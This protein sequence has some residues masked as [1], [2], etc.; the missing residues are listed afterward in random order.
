M[1]LP[2]YPFDNSVPAGPNN[3]SADQPDMLSNNQS[4]LLI[5]KADH[6]GYNVNS[7]GYHPQVRMP[8]YTTYS[9]PIGAALPPVILGFG[10]L[11]CNAGVDLIGGANTALFYTPD[12]TG[13]A[14]QLT[15]TDLTNYLLFGTLTQ[16]YNSVGNTYWGGW[17]FLP[18]GLIKQYGN[19]TNVTSSG[20]TTVIF[21]ITFPAA[22]FNVQ[23]TIV[24]SDNSTIRFSLQGNPTTA[25]FVTTQTSSS[26][27]TNLYWEALGN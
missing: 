17:T 21:P 27:F 25:Q 18:G 1:T 3:P 16:N 24:T 22:V 11:Y 9:P 12:A 14:Y 20:S 8:N 5:W 6:F 15:R 13:K 19:T 10:G 23:C 2:M 7:S 4:D 26:K